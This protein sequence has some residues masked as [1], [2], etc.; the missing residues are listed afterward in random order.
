MVGRGGRQDIRLARCDDGDVQHGRRRRAPAEQG[1]AGQVNLVEPGGVGEI[2]QPV[3]GDAGWQAGI[4]QGDQPVRADEPGQQIVQ[5]GQQVTAAGEQVTQRGVDRRL[6]GDRR[7][8]QLHRQVR[9]AGLPA[10]HTAG[11]RGRRGAGPGR[12]QTGQQGGK[13]VCAGVEG[14][15]EQGQPPGLVRAPGANGT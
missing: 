1:Q 10:H 13:Q 9:V 6:R 8:Q 3:P 12:L 4:R 15:A 14:I 2:G 11:E 7:Q 5:A